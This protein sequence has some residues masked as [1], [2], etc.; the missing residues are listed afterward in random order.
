MRKPGVLE[1]GPKGVTTSS[2]R[3]R[4]LG[5]EL[6]H[7]AALAAIADERSFRGAA[8]RLGY[9]QSAISRQIAYLER[10]TGMRLIERSHG[11]RPVHLTE[12]GEALLAYAN[13]I[14]ASIESAQAELGDLDQGRSGE[15][16]VGIFQG[17][18]TRILPPALVAFGR[19]YPDVRVVA[20]EAMTDAPLLDLVRKGSLDLAFANL[21]LEPGSPFEACELIRVPW[22]LVVPAS[23]QLASR[24]EPL[25]A[26]EIARLPLIGSKSPGADPWTGSSLGGNGQG[27]RVVFRCEGMHTMQA[28]AAVGLGAGVV[29]KLALQEGDPRTAAVELGDFLEPA[30]IGLVWLRQRRLTGAILQFRELM[31]QVAAAIERQQ[32]ATG[33]FARAEEAGEPALAQRV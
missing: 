18:P 20:S 16:R 33:R 13:D 17:V 7:F 12:A 28:L 11:P 26:Q 29:P 19:R 4:W 27:P 8:E 22:V 9:V 10:V 14:L 5:I 31:R 21:P 15:V 23:S 30:R 25:S 1:V 6:R 24:E 2:T 32:A 3:D